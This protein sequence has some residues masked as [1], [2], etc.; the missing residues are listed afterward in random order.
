MN[1]LAWRS[2]ACGNSEEAVTIQSGLPEFRVS[3]DRG[4]RYGLDFD[5]R[6]NRSEFEG[7]EGADIQS[8]CDRIIT[9]ASVPTRR[10]CYG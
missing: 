5:V 4:K 3:E 7:N 10:I 1:S 6:G 8:T 9:A 2:S